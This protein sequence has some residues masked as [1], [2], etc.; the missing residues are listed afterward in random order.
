MAVNRLPNI[1]GGVQPT[2]FT[3]K[4]DIIAA[5]A[6]ANPVRLGVGTDAQILVADSTASTGLKWATATAVSGPA[7]SAYRTSSTQALTASTFTKAQLNAEYFDTDSCFDSTT[8]YR[9]TPTK[10]GKYQV[11]VVSV[12]GQTSA[13]RAIMVVAL[14][15]TDYC[16]VYDNT[17]SYASPTGGS[18]FLLDMNGTTDYIELFVYS[19]VT[20]TLNNTTSGSGTIFSATWIRS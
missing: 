7:F 12:I 15:G 17:T 4:G 16:R 14:N 11:N 18:A 13:A 8:N 6:A 9:F 3:T 1:E 10:A 19:A 2:L 20:A 5:S